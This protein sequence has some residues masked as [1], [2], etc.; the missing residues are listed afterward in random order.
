MIKA[1]LL[2]LDDT[3]LGNPPRYFTEQYLGLLDGFVRERLGMASIV[4][5]LLDGTRAVLASSDPMRTNAEVFYDVVEPRLTV[6]RAR[7]D[8]TVAEF[9]ACVYPQLEGITQCRPGARRLVEWLLEAGYMVA[10]ATNPLFPTVAVDQRLA[11]AGLPVD[12][13]PFMF[14]TT[15]DNMHF[16]KPTPSYYEEILGR[17]GMQADE[18]IMVGDDWE[19]DIVPARAAGLNTFWVC[20]DGCGCDA[21]AQPMVDGCGTLADFASR[22]QDEDWLN[23]L[24]PQ[25]VTPDMVMPR[26]IGNLAAVAGVVREAPAHVWHMHPDEAEWSPVEVLC[27]L[28]D[29]ERDVQRPRLERIL[30]EDNPFLSRPKAPLA[31]ASRVC[32]ESA[33]QVA[34]AFAAERQMTLD[35]LATVP[36]EAWDRPARHYI[37]GPTTFLEMAAFTAQHDRLHLVQLC[38]TIGQCV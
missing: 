15:L 26:L 4:R 8:E 19:N 38:Q 22:V 18:A 13:V 31:P 33:W 6:E 12:E 10:V 28:V 24:R 14:V 29:S 17:V 34:Q 7:F 1:V 20:P 23:T 2:D 32:P 37:F 9:Y 5:D 3:L 25:A 27:H 30:A 36:D 16:A 21:T 11:W 35:W